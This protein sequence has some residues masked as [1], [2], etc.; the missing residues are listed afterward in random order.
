MK[1]TLSLLGADLTTF[2][3]PEE[4]GVRHLTT[5]R[6]CTTAHL[7]NSTLVG[8]L[9]NRLISAGCRQKQPLIRAYSS[10]VAQ[11]TRP[12]LAGLL[13]TK[14]T[15][16]RVLFDNDS[17]LPYKKIVPILQSVYTNLDHPEDIRLPKY[18]RKHDL[19]LCKDLLKT[20]RNTT[21]SMNRNLV[22]LENELVQ[23][24]A[25]LGD[26]DAI[27]ML[28]FETIEAGT[29]SKEDYRYANDLLKKLTD[30]QHPLVFKMA[31]DLA[32]KKGFHDQAEQ[33][34]LQ[35]I[36]LEPDT[37]SAA[38]IYLNLGVYYF[39]YQKPRADL[40]RARIC[41]EKSIKY[42]EL[43]T[44]TLKSHYYLGQLYSSTD[45]RLAKHHLQIAA[46]RGLKE[47]FA[48]LG[49]L[50]MNLFNNYQ[51]SIEWFK[52]G[53]EASNDLT[54][55]IG[56]FD[57]YV[58]LKEFK[59]AFQILHNLKSLKEKME[60]VINLGKVP[61]EHQES[62]LVNYPVLQTFFLTRQASIAVINSNL[63]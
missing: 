1:H 7:E 18:T 53:V 13:P 23:Q 31:G 61:K 48:A 58:S 49:F 5:C 21:N 56:Q 55:L 19:M 46:S 15:M 52:L 3:R 59:N 45:P 38:Q 35:F 63:V 60:R 4:E 28:A 36:E 30:M 62:M 44:F 22:D 47:S 11:A 8:Y 32:F 34:W 51:K 57:C 41:F 26:N 14:K 27:A 37:I 16:N 12:E 6:A 50:E 24:A 29:S 9:M 54:C 25:E 39:T 40:T 43:D 20:V 17:R 10:V 42:G 2:M 33:Y